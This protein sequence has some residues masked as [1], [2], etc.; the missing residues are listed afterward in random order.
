M[1]IEQTKNMLKSVQVSELPGIISRIEQENDSRVGIKKLLEFYKKWYNNYIE[2][3][4]RLESML[5][6]EKQYYGEYEYI[7]GVDEAGCGPLAGP[8]VAAAVVLPKN[9]TIEKLKDSKKLSAKRRE[10]LYEIII[11]KAV[12]YAI[13]EIGYL[14]IDEM[15][16]LNARLAAMGDAVMQLGIADFALIDGLRQPTGINI[17]CAMIANG[18]SLSMS[19][20]AASVLAKVHR[21]KI[22]LKYADKFPDYGFERHKGYGTLEHMTALQNFGATPIHRKTFIRGLI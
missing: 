14:Q 17:E 21:D 19:I 9:C 6:F 1:T 18:D 12:G 15:N 16:I 11:E 2:E 5:F 22:M 7:C 20:A 3:G 4:K 10:E 13:A 8:V